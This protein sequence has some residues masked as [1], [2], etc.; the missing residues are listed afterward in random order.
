MLDILHVTPE[1]VPF[2]KSGGLADVLNALPRAQARMGHRVAVV[3]PLYDAVDLARHHVTP[4]GRSFP[5][6]LGGRTFEFDVAQA[7]MGDGVT[8]WFLRNDDLF[9]RPRLYGDGNVDYA[10]NHLRFAFFSAAVFRM[11]RALRLR[12]DVVHCHDWQSG[13]VP[14]Y[15]RL[16]LLD[17]HATVMTVHNL[18]YQGLFPAHVLPE[19]G[20]PWEVFKPDG[21]EFYGKANFL[22]AGLVW[23]DRVTTVSPTYAAE[24]L[25]PDAGAGLDGVLRARRTDFVGIL[26]GADY[27]VWD[28][29]HDSHI[30]APFG[31]D[32]LSG[33]A[34]CRE[35]LL[36]EMGLPPFEG[37]LFGVIGRLASQKGHDLVAAAMPAIVAQGGGLVVLGS[38]DA[39][40]EQAI[41]AAARLH[42]DRVAVRIAYD[43]GLAH[44]IEAGSDFFLMP[45]RYEPCGLNQIYSMRYGTLPIVHAV[46]GLED[47]VIDLG[48]SPEE[49]TGLKFRAFEVAAFL[50]ALARAFDLVRDPERHHAA[51][52]RAMAVDFGWGASARGY[53]ALYEA[54][55]A[56]DKRVPEQNP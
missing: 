37:P 43:D 25:H 34:A 26:N 22:K 45:S 54:I 50:G 15:N 18:A 20:L 5:V 28:P 40:I 16:H 35:A 4:A 53:L 24:V 44:R 55:L 1:V 13:L 36:Q 39:E 42:P 48:E 38:G 33:K 19:V 27:T 17:L 29:R 47:T 30:A 46:G 8:C 14:A 12:P 3:T 21:I 51:V 32:D 6:T 52:Q 31:P 7:A 23:A 41:V 49:G 10:D 56:L 2:S 11:M 9:G